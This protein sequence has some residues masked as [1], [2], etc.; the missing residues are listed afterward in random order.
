M[1]RGHSGPDS[2]A[3][4]G[5]WGAVAGA[6]LLPQPPFPARLPAVV[7]R[8]LG[9]QAGCVVPAWVP[10]AALSW[11]HSGWGDAAFAGVISTP[12]SHG[13][14]VNAKLRGLTLTSVLFTRVN[15]SGI[16]I[17]VDLRM[18]RG[19]LGPH[20]PSQLP[21]GAVP[22][23]TH[24]DMCVQGPSS[25]SCLWFGGYGVGSMGRWLRPLRHVCGP[26]LGRGKSPKSAGE[27]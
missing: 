12:R 1:A 20:S 13:R 19:V 21:R 6:H 14:G 7:W 3:R 5:L 23:R 15:P 18:L 2:A 4:A 11:S 27:S 25:P 10:C 17:H 8:M 22:S 16:R 24:P 9:G 26:G